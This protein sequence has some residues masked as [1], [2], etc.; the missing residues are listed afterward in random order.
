[1]LQ[2][3]HN[4][5]KFQIYLQMDDSLKT[6]SLLRVWEQESPM[7]PE[8]YVCLYN[9]QMHLALKQWETNGENQV[10][11]HALP[12]IDTAIQLFPRRLDMRLGKM[13]VLHHMQWEDA[14]FETARKLLDEGKKHGQQWLWTYN[15]EIKNADEA[16]SQA[17]EEYMEAWNDMARS[18]KLT[19]LFL[20]YFPRYLPMLMR[21]A[22]LYYLQK[23]WDRGIKLLEK[24]FK[25]EQG[26]P[27]LALRLG[28][29]Y[30]NTGKLKS[31]EKMYQFA[32]D[33]GFGYISEE[34]EMRLKS[35]KP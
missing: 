31:A 30:E 18:Q 32:L 27:E 34:A 11:Y 17:F 9:Y 4:M 6:D 26:N 25:A 5:E 12:A 8:R 28:I 33:Y 10:R 19:T 35:L 16:I 14:F 20:E 23:D 1:M 24:A 13:F 7:D 15:Q 2:A 29:G 3:Q 22:E 21:Q